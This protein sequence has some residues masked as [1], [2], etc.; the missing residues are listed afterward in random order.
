MLGLLV[1]RC[2]PAVSRDMNGNVGGKIGLGFEMGWSALALELGFMSF[3]L[4]GIDRRNEQNITTAL[5]S[6]LR[7]SRYQDVSVYRGVLEERGDVSA[8]LLLDAQS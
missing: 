6:L 4:F 1:L 5:A 3:L 2:L 7:I 8:L